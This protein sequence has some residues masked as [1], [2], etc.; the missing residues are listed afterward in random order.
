MSDDR[1]IGEGYPEEQPPGAGGG[2]EEKSGGGGPASDRAPDTDSDDEG[3]PGQATG[4][5]G[6]AG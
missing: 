2:G 1:D 6:A 5:P 4:N 3:E